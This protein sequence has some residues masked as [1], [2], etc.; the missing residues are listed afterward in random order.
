[1]TEIAEEAILQVSSPAAGGAA[2][3]WGATL[4]GLFAV[5]H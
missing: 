3:G 5:T 4:G 1:M 2:A